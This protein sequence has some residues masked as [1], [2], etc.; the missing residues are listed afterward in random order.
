MEVSIAARTM[1]DSLPSTDSLH[2]QPLIRRCTNAVMNKGRHRCGQRPVF[3]TPELLL[4]NAVQPIATL[5]P[6]GLDLQIML[7]GCGGQ[8]APHA[9]RPGVRLPARGLPD[10]GQ[11]GSLGASYHRQDLGALALGQ[12]CGGLLRGDRF[13]L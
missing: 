2:I 10:L 5:S 12:R 1:S 11:R 4:L 9:V 13:R 7:L 8:E 3:W 6:R